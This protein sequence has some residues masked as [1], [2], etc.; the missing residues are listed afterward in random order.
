MNDDV[1]MGSVVGRPEFQGLDAGDPGGEPWLAGG[2]KQAAA[3]A[4]DTE[5]EVVAVLGSRRLT[6]AE[7]L[8]LRKGQAL[9]LDRDVNAP[10]DLMVAG[11]LVAHGEL[12]VVDEQFGIRILALADR[13]AS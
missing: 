1:D 8:A 3:S 13:D 2:V 9:A 5:L 11:R 6:V 7:L 10:V 4:A 12:V